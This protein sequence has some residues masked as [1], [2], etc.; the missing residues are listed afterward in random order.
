MT[1]ENGSTAVA[2][3]MD[4]IPEGTEIIIS[5]F[6][7]DANDT[8]YEIKRADQIPV[9]SNGK[10]S[11]TFITREQQ[12]SIVAHCKKNGVSADELYAYI[13]KALGINKRSEIPV[14]NYDFVM[15]WI[16]KQDSKKKQAVDEKEE[17]VPF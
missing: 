5:R 6:G 15:N 12:E 14:A 13:K 10:N 7:S 11:P 1:W 17:D 16:S 4:Q 2:E 3:A 9:H 8:K